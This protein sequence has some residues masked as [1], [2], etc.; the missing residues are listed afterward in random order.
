MNKDKN[1]KMVQHRYLSQ[2]Q[3]FHNHLKNKMLI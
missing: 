2:N 1:R 3:K